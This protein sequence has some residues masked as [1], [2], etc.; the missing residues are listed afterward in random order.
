MLFF[1]CILA[2]FRSC[3][4]APAFQKKFTQLLLP[5]MGCPELRRRC[6]VMKINNCDLAWRAALGCI[7]TSDDKGVKHFVLHPLW[8]VSSGDALLSTVSPELHARTASATIC[9]AGYETDPE[10]PAAFRRTKEIFSLYF[11]TAPK[12]QIKGREI[13]HMEEPAHS[14]F[15]VVLGYRHYFTEVKCTY[16]NRTARSWSSSHSRS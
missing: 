8:K 2:A 4:C 11:F 16:V 15:F 1:S 10:E 9:R 7:G 3:A 12:T 14:Q 6:P 13:L 5:V